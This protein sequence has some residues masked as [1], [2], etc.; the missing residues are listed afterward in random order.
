MIAKI[1]VSAATYAI[2]KPYSYWI[3]AELQLLPGMRVL[4]PFGRSNRRSE[5]VVLT[6]AEGSADGLKP[7][8]CC[9]DPQPLLD[10]NMLRL[11]AFMRER[12]F[13]T[14]YDAIRAMLPAGLWFQT[15]D[16]FTRTGEPWSEKT[17]RQKDALKILADITVKLND[18]FN[19]NEDV[20]EQM[21]MVS[22]KYDHIC[23]VCSTEVSRRPISKEEA[24]EMYGLIEK[25]KQNK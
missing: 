5:G 13:C 22:A 23:P 16:R 17:I 21:V 20:K 6:V 1:A 4:V 2:D 8:E 3:P 15:K 10:E 18:K 24:M 7:V 9:L 11:A 14:F 12:Y 25:E 19:V